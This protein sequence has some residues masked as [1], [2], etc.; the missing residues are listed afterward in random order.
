MKPATDREM[1][2]ILAKLRV[3][4]T[5]VD[6]CPVSK[7]RQPSQL[8][9]FSCMM[10]DLN[11][12]VD[13]LIALRAFKDQITQYGTH[14]TKLEAVLRPEILGKLKEEMEKAEKNKDSVIN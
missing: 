5:E 4:C 7:A 14:L 1:R 12:M 3:V 9:C 2:V 6:D 10:V 11:S 13:E 8:D